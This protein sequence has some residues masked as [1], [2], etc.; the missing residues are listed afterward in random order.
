VI[1]EAPCRARAPGA[2]RQ[3]SEARELIAA[4]SEVDRALWA[5]AFYGGLRRA[6]LLALDWANVDLVEG[7]IRVER[8]WDVVEGLIEPKSRAGRRQVPVPTVLRKHLAEHRLRQGRGGDGLVFGRSK[9]TPFVPTEP[10][11]RAK[12]TWLAAGYLPIGLHEAR[13]TYASFM[14]AAGVT[15]GT[16]PVA[17]AKQ[18]SEFM[19]HA[20]ISVTLD[21]YGHLFPGAEGEA[22]RA[23]DAYLDR[24]ISG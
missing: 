19:G 23:L 16:N 18:L 4:L 22:A 3:P 14:I 10:G 17:V 24:T 21:R 15:A 20:S 7:V 5:T 1:A 2:D 6:E 13:H 12:R 8:S 11:Q 9:T